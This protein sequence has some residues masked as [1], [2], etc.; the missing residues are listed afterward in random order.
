MDLS[1]CDYQ[2]TIVRIGKKR[3]IVISYFAAFHVVWSVRQ[4]EGHSLQ[5]SNAGSHGVGCIPT[6][7]QHC[8]V[9]CGDGDLGA[10]HKSGITQKQL[11][12]SY[13]SVNVKAIKQKT[14]DPWK[15]FY[16]ST[17]W[18]QSSS[19]RYLCGPNLVHNMDWVE[20]GLLYNTEHWTSKT[21]SGA[22]TKFKPNRYLRYL[23]T[24]EH[25]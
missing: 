24:L 3:E 22:Y 8:K 21:T 5:L 25:L 12:E 18:F 23:W 9:M 1:G 10:R 2:R 20:V 16:K 4:E 14:P 11:Y 6:T 19:S 17:F 15:P 13:S 7:A